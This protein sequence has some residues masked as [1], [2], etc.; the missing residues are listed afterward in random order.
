MPIYER[1][2][3]VWREVWSAHVKIDGNWRDVDISGKVNNNWK[4]SHK[5]IIDERDIIGFR[6][7]YKVNPNRIYPKFPEL[8]TNL[9]IPVDFGLSGNISG[10]N[11]E[12]KGVVFHYERFGYEEG[13]YMYE[14]SLYAVL[15]NGCLVD[16]SLTKD[17]K[18][19]NDDE[20]I[21]TNIP[22]GVKQ[23][24]AT[25]KTKN[26]LIEIQAHLTYEM[27]R[28]YMYGWNS[29]FDTE[30]FLYDLPNINDNN[31]DKKDL[32][33]IE[34]RIILPTTTRLNSFSPVSSIGVARNLKIEETM[35]GGYGILDQTINFIKVNGV[36]KPFV[37]E[38]Y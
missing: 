20:R 31:V 34:S 13:I 16:V 29:F 15:E 24:W 6:L 33:V 12:I 2:D 25:N 21:L 35:M 22:P 8:K 28:Y 19:N 38:I 32:K 1:I 18:I 5:H 10:M 26:L 11:T 36:I 14:G 3:G 30:D 23:V 17:T 37:I 27:S 7:V 4:N 9:K